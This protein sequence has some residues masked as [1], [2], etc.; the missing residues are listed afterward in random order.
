VLVAGRLLRVRPQSLDAN[1]PPGPR[2]SLLLGSGLALRRDF[3]ETFRQAQRE[4]GDIV[5]FE[6]G[7]PGLRTSL[8]AL[9]HPDHVR[10]VLATGADLYRKENVFYDEVRWAFGN[11][12]LN[13]EDESWRRQRRFVQPV[14]TRRRIEGYAGDMA[15][16]SVKLVER[17]REVAA[18]EG[19]VDLHAAMSDLTLR[20]VGRALFGSDLERAVAVF[21]HATPVLGEYGR[22]RAFLPVRPPREWPTPANRRAARAKRDLYAVCDEIISRRR[23]GD[24]TSD[25]L[26]SLLTDA[27][28]E[29]EALDDTE[30]RD[31][32]L[33]FLFAGHDTTTIALTFALHLLGRHP[34][35]QDRVREE[36]GAVLGGRA[37]TA[38]DIAALPYTAM[39]LK[40]AMRLYPPV[41]AYGRRSAGPQRIGAYDIPSHSDVYVSQWVTHRHPEFWDDADRFYPERFTREREAARHRHAYFP[42]GAGPRACIGQH[43]AMLEGVI[44]LAA[45][46]GRIALATPSDSIS[47]APRITLH[48]IS[49][50][51]CRLTLPG[52]AHRPASRRTGIAGAGAR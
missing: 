10:Q 29:G 24:G 12:L 15:S 39:V 50:M 17:W 14:F 31:Q 33:I 41:Y 18:R 51:P 44:A 46:V 13:S 16:E 34:E 20:V 1:A 5:R 3:L 19:V 4:H 35:V 40:E 28:A 9:F 36:A 42:F 21:V 27:R 48:P 38:A 8:Y 30:I 25:D 2:G 26:L 7:P 37:P 43:F 23:A 22:R 11:G 32:V 49:G 47:L 45:I 52:A 6:T